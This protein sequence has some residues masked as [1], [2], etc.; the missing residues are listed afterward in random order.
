MTKAAKKLAKAAVAVAAIAVATGGMVPTLLHYRGYQLPV[1]HDHT[2]K[3]AILHWSRQIGKS[4]TLAGWAVDRLLKQLQTHDT[5]LVTVLSN[6]RANGGEFVLKVHEV[7]RKLGQAFVEDGNRE[8]LADD[9]TM[10]EDAKLELMRFEVRLQVGQKL[11]RIIVLA[12]NPRTARGFSGD[13]ILDEF[14][15]H[16]DSRAIWE[17]AEP[18]ISANPEFLCRISSTGNGRRNMFYQLIAEGRI[19]YY[20]MR[21]SD[22]WKRGEI[23]IYSVVTGEEITPDQARAEASDKR[24]YDQNYE[25][26]F[27]DEASALLTQELISAAEREGIA[28]EHQ[29]WSEATIER[30]R[31]KTIGDLFLGQDVGR[32]RDFSVQTVIERIGSGY[33]VV[34]MLRM[35]NMRLPAQQRE[36]EKICKLPKF[37]SAE[38]DMTGLG[39]GL[40]EYAQEEPW[41][42]NVRGVNFGSSEPIS[43]KLRADGKKGETAPVTELMATELL[44]VFEDKRI[45]IPMDPELR[46]DLRK[47]E[48]LVSPSGRVSI[49]AVRDEA[50]HADHFWSVALAV[51]ASVRGGVPFAYSPVRG[52][53]RGRDGMRRRLLDKKA[54]TL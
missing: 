51:R 41:G 16:Q 15:F 45:E 35:E 6:S 33:R 30:L 27:N 43:L 1:I 36:L 22:A 18:I 26:E 14:A 25:G 53:H 7:C 9:K 23:R 54:V 4:T 38:I 19:P 20:R 50:G 11:G 42:G 2:T 31:T 8:A 40:V 37:R 39:L 32:K 13:L 46:D 21:R 34:A 12:A 29:E 52:A 17:A 44:G 10:S 28:I 47:P 5:W 48:K 49:A 24:A 3:T